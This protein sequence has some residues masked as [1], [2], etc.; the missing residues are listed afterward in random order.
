MLLMFMVKHSK[1]HYDHSCPA[2]FSL[3]CV[4]GVNA[5]NKH[6]HDPPKNQHCVDKSLIYK[7]HPRFFHYP[8]MVSEAHDFFF[9]HGFSGSYFFDIHRFGCPWFFH[10]TR[11]SLPTVFQFH[12]PW[13]LYPDD[14][15]TESNHLLQSNYIT[16]LKNSKPKYNRNLVKSWLNSHE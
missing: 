16:T 11:F 6:S 1:N 10:Y 2:L 8:F 3:I 12:F 4:E 7:Q 14:V 5:R 15:W 9:T 13:F